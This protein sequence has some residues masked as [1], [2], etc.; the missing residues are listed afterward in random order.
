MEKTTLKKPVRYVGI[1]ENLIYGL[2]NSGQVFSYNMF[3]GSYLSIFFVKVFG[4]PSGAVATMVFILGIW[5][6]INDPLMGAVI[7]KTRTRY[8]K[9]RPYL[10]LVPIPLSI[11]TILFWGGPLLLQNTKELTVKIVYMY[12]SY[13]L[14][15][16]FYTLGD[17]PF[18]SMSAAISPTPSDRA[19]NCK[20]KNHQQ[21]Y[22]RN[23]NRNH[24]SGSYGL[25]HKGKNFDEP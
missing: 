17:V 3:T 6:V 7:D 12:I 13:L 11:A 18:W 23:F 1:K 14:W 19:R 5:D 16:F 4:I 25:E 8:G 21:Y 15:E 2:A 22:R 24:A 10:L 9:L 20:R